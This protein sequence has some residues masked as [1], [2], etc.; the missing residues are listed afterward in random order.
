MLPC[1]LCNYRVECI[2]KWKEEN[3]SPIDIKKCNGCQ[4]CELACSFHCLMLPNVPE[5]L[6]GD[7]DWPRSKQS[8][9]LVN[10]P[11][12][13]NKKRYVLNQSTNRSLWIY[14]IDTTLFNDMGRL[15]EI[16][17]TCNENI[18]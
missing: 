16:V 5:F 18:L 11:F 14:L 7:L 3:K 1:Y 6:Y 10:I 13:E 15:I 2:A 12:K 17:E 9:S 4:S 8:R